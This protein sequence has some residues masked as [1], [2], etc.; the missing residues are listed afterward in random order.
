[1]EKRFFVQFFVIVLLFTSCNKNGG[2]NEGRINIS[3][4]WKSEK[5]IVWRT[6]AGTLPGEA[7]PGVLF[8]DTSAYT[9]EYLYFG[10]DRK[11]YIST[12]REDLHEAGS[13]VVILGRMPLYRNPDNP[14]FR[15]TLD[16]ALDGRRLIIK[17]GLLLKIS[18]IV[19]VT[20]N[21]LVLY[22]K[23]ERPE[24]ATE[25]WFYYSK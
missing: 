21:G 3:G 22:K 5:M 11:V 10:L 23:E 12:E 4:D 15:D 9:G 20:K 1:M 13:P 18:E 6:K 2:D 16:Y 14:I 24:A 17:G 25:Y 19:D 7:T 8:R